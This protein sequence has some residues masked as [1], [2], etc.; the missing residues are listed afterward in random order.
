MFFHLNSQYEVERNVD[1]TERGHR[2][3]EIN[4]INDSERVKPTGVS[5]SEKE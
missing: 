4:K 5:K 1:V 2:Q 3:A